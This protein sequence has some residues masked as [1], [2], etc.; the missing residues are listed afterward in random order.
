LVRR[1]VNSASYGSAI[2]TLV[3]CRQ[4]AGL[5]QRDL[6][7]ALGKP[8]SYVAKVERLERRLDL[9]EFIAIARALGRSGSDLV[10]EIEAS[11]PNTL[12][13]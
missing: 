11:L 12:D 8:Q 13:F 10:A 1:W 3:R 5:S 7:A 9:I 6:A 4:D 2:T